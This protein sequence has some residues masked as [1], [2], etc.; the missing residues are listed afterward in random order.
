[1]AVLRA[2]E[3]EECALAT[4]IFP[5]RIYPFI[6]GKLLILV[7]SEVP[8]WECPVIHRNPAF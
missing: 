2:P 7:P 4:A 8:K 1:M 5:N 3:L 6:R